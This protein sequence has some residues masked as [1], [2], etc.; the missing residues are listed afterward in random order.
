MI[1]FLFDFKFTRYRAL[2]KRKLVRAR[3]R[4][5]FYLIL[6]LCEHCTTTAMNVAV[7]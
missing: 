5:G 6:C 7:K 3:P 2:R 1:L 4:M